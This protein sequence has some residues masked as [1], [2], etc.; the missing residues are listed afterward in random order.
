MRSIR[1]PF[2]IDLKRAD[3]KP[4]IRAL[5]L[6]ER[7][8]RDFVQ[9]GPLINRI[10]TGRINGA[11]RVDGKPLP[12]VAPRH[13]A[14]RARQQAALHARLDPAKD[15]LWDDETLN[16]LI[17]AVCGNTGADTIGPAAQQA[18]GRLFD[19]K[20][21]GNSES[22]AAARDLDDAVR[23]P[24]LIR[25]LMLYATGKLRH[26]RRLLAQRVDG[27]LAGVHGT[28]VAVHN[29][30]RGFA[31]M[32]EL[33]SAQPRPSPDDVLRACLFAPKTVLRQATAPGATIAGEVRPG[34]LVLL[35]L[36]TLRERSPDAEAVFMAGTWAEC[37]AGAFVAGLMRAVWVGAI[38]AEAA[39][40]RS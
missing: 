30:V 23:T 19:P 3:D 37:P 39:E 36:D 8:D 6:D 31:R 29:M 26:S 10:L 7:L 35:E 14:E 12:A 2:L 32:R 4:D 20:Y 33:W 1:I 15:R 28:G 17:A 13:D 11:L 21:V 40:K 27:D 38:A 9:R 22:F 34:T 24:N 18:V 16:A 5:T 25:W